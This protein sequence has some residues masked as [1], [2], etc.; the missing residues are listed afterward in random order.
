MSGPPPPIIA[1]APARTT[2]AG[3]CPANASRVAPVA[4]SMSAHTAEK[5]ISALWYFL[6]MA[7]LSCASSDDGAAAL[8]RT[9]SYSLLMNIV[10]RHA[11]TPC[12]VASA[13]NTRS[14]P[15]SAAT[16]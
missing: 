10:V 2:H 9:I 4:R 16:A 15:S 12:P 11:R 14:N 8:L 6:A 5:S 3:G 1:A 13:T 7:S